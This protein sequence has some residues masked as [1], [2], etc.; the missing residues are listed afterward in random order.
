MLHFISV[1]VECYKEQPPL[2][3][4]SVLFLDRG[5]RPLGRIFDVMGPVTEPLYCVRF[6]SKEHIEEHNVQPG[7]LVYSAPQTEHSQF[8]FLKHLMM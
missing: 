4:D 8:V 5:A 6:N 1:V 2:D 7:M 3:I